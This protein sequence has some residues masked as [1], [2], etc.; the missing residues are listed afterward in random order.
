VAPGKRRDRTTP[1]YEQS[2]AGI[3]RERRMQSGD[4]AGTTYEAF[5]AVQGG[6][7]ETKDGVRWSK[8]ES[9]CMIRPT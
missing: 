8:I 7:G 3:I 9:M 1:S 2:E 5:R 4:K 6:R